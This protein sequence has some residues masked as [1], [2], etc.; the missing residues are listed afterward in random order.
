MGITEFLASYITAFIG[1]TGY[2]SVFVLMIMES[3]VFPI[4]SEAVMPFAGFL[5]VSGKFTIFLVFLVSTLGSIVG[6]LLSYAIGLYGGK[7]FIEKYGKYFLLNHE[8]LVAT[9]KFFNKYGEI[10][11]LISRFIPVV[12][13]LISLP[14][15]TARM[16]LWKFSLYTTIGA[17]CWNT[18][19]AV[20]GMYMKEKW[21]TIMKY[22]ETIDKFVL[23]ILA[24]GVIY[25]IYKHVNHKMSKQDKITL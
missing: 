24:L 22:N 18:I 15:G 20:A 9:E 16:N 11:I 6:S 4:P 14:A 17:G 2:I 10:T 8:D 23:V 19:L 7:P 13:H 3:M 12:R 1:S 5:V 21:E 25:F